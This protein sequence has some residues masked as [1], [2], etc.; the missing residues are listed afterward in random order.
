MKGFLVG[1]QGR[2]QLGLPDEPRLEVSEAATSLECLGNSHHPCTHFLPRPPCASSVVGDLRYREEKDKAGE[3]PRKTERDL[4]KG[5]A[6]DGL[7]TVS[8]AG[9][10]KPALRVHG[11]W[12]Q[13][14][15]RGADHN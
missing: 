2:F 6:P 4:G 8:L 5:E 14:I 11:V 15:P 12:A 13:G 3:S 10:E 9:Q 1:P 7:W